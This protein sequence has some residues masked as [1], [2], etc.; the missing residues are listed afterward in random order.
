MHFP[1]FR[2][3]VLV[4]EERVT[5]LCRP[6]QV[7]LFELFQPLLAELLNLLEGFFDLPDL[8]FMSFFDDFQGIEPLKLQGSGEFSLQLDRSFLRSV[9]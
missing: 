6:F 3:D 7:C 9:P 2:H 4:D 8:L 1:E 5:F